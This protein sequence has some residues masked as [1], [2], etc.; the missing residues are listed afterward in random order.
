MKKIFNFIKK[1]FNTDVDVELKSM[2]DHLNM[3]VNNNAENDVIELHIKKIE[4]HLIG[5]SNR[6]VVS[7]N[8]RYVGQTLE[9]KHI[10]NP[11]IL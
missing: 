7:Y 3:L 6:I 11:F 10:E 5:T 4:K 1:L 9:K 2:C 8:D